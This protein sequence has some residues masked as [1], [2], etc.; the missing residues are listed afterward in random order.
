MPVKSGRQ[1]PHRVQPPSEP[2]RI[3]MTLQVPAE[4]VEKFLHRVR[5]PHAPVPLG[6]PP[7][8][9]LHFHYVNV[10]GDV[11]TSFD[12]QPART[13]LDEGK[14]RL[15]DAPQ[16]LRFVV[17][18]QPLLWQLARA[19]PAVS[20]PVMSRLF[21]Q[22][23]CRRTARLHR[24]RRTSVS[25]FIADVERAT[26]RAHY[27]EFTRASRL[28]GRSDNARQSALVD[29]YTIFETRRWTIACRSHASLARPALGFPRRDATKAA[30][31]AA[32]A[33][34]VKLGNPQ[35]KGADGPGAYGGPP[36]LRARLQRY[37]PRPGPSGAR[38]TAPGLRWP[39]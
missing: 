16:C 9:L 1:G 5:K 33:R 14:V 35:R 21:R 11:R 34:G 2:P 24:R 30:L 37:R 4:P 17:E 23:G 8:L 26:C 29:T 32:K 18:R 12:L 38:Q 39:P 31:A 25:S 15:V 3:R 19:A 10:P 6:E 36:A 13:L 27:L 22:A 28:I 7:H 20:E